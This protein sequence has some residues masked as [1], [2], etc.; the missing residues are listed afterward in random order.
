MPY[1]PT[2][3]FFETITPLSTLAPLLIGRLGGQLPAVGIEVSNPRRDIPRR[4]EFAG[5]EGAL[6]FLRRHD[7]VTRRLW[8]T[9]ALARLTVWSP[10]PDLLGVDGW[11][12]PI[13]SQ[14][15]PG[16]RRRLVLALHQVLAHHCGAQLIYTS[17]QED[18]YAGE[19]SHGSLVR[20]C[21]QHLDQGENLAPLLFEELAP[22]FWLIT[23][24]QGLL[25]GSGPSA[26]FEQIRR[27]DGF[28]S[29]ENFTDRPLFL[30]QP[31]LVPGSADERS[32]PREGTTQSWS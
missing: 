17:G 19:P 32:S 2:F 23:A 13:G 12:S 18:S 1:H 4:L 31:E 14:A 21:R 28:D 16:E 22:Y 15:S 26:A 5:P 10:G 7:V 30:R 3:A 27:T 20:Q 29:F 24:R 6:D 11:E 8:M 9:G 25:N